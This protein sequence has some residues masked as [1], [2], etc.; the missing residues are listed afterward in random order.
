MPGGLSG[1]YFWAVNPVFLRRVDRDSI[2]AVVRDLIRVGE[3]S[4]A[5]AA[6]DD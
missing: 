2:E 6:E 5:F 1:R 3:L 4:S